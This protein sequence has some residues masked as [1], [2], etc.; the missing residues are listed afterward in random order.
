MK[1]RSAFRSRRVRALLG[2][3][4]CVTLVAGVHA[5]PLAVTNLRQYRDLVREVRAGLRGARLV[6]GT[7][8]V[9]QAQGNDCGA[10][11]LKMILAYHG[12]E[13]RLSDLVR[14]AGTRPEGASLRDLRVVARG[15]GLQSRSWRICG[16]D[17]RRVPLPAIAFI[18]G[19]HFVVIRR[20]VERELLEVDDP[21][22]GRLWW[23]VQAFRRAWSGKLL[24]FDQSWSPP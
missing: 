11:C 20:F 14:A 1:A 6:R 19:N 17:L 7:G 13:R 8:T 12:I 3:F 5:L 9:L 2:L 4:A 21:A 18:N 16:D 24:V 15:E 23:P 22:L 10:A